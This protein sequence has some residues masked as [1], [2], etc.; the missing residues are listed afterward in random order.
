MKPIY[1]LYIL[2]YEREREREM[3]AKERTFWRLNADR[4]ETFA[5]GQRQDNRLD[6]LKN[7]KNG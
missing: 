5:M 6:Q 7:I 1:K 3:N 4:L 2:V